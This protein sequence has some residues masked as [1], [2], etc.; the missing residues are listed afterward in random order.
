M[1]TMVGLTVA[2]SEDSV[3]ELSICVSVKYKSAFTFA[4]DSTALLRYSN[5]RLTDAEIS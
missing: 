4:L 5:D 3:E 2:T 1:P